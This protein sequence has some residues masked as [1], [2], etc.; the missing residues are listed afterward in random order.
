VNAKIHYLKNGEGFKH[1]FYDAVFF[2]KMKGMLG[3]NVRAIVTGSAPI[4]RNVMDFLKICFCCPIGEGY[5][6]TET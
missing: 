3:G 1:K 5:G 6:L 2:S 4:D